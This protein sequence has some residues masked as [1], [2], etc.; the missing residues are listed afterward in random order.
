MQVS[1]F[2]L[3]SKECFSCV[4]G[5]I[6]ILHDWIAQ[7]SPLA[8]TNP[9]SVFNNSSGTG[10]SEIRLSKTVRIQIMKQFGIQ[11]VAKYLDNYWDKR[12]SGIQMVV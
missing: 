10:V 11:M 3:V 12:L 7:D 9:E 1:L 8:C 4:D 6:I 5:V 2:G